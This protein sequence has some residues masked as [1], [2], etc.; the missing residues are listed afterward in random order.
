MN[1]KG[2]GSF[3]V[4]IAWHCVNNRKK[5]GWSKESIMRIS[6]RKALPILRGYIPRPLVEVI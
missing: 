1:M 3:Q 2:M 5:T 4:S 6:C